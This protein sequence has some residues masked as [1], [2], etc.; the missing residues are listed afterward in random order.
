MATYDPTGTPRRG[1][2]DGG[3]GGFGANVASALPQVAQASPNFDSSGV[4]MAANKYSGLGLG[5][6]DSTMHIQD[7]YGIAMRD[8]LKQTGDAA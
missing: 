4:L 6:S 7:P 8:Q 3:A 2:F 1:E 5:S